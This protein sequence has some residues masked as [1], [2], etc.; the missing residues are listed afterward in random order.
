MKRPVSTHRC[1]RYRPRRCPAE[2]SA[3]DRTDKERKQG[4]GTTVIAAIREYLSDILGAFMPGMYFSLNLLVSTIL[5]V[6]MTKGQSWKNVITFINDLPQSAVLQTVTPFAVFAF[7]L[8]SYIIGSA[9][10]RKDIKEP[11]TASAIQT[12]RKS[13]DKEKEGLAFDFKDAGGKPFKLLSGLYMRMNFRVD[14]PYSHL[15]RYLKTRN[16]THLAE[17]IPWEGDEN[18]EKAKQ[19]SKMFINILKVR[20]H[21]FAPSEMPEIEKNE[22][23]IRLMNSLWYAAKTI[24]NISIPVLISTTAFYILRVLLTGKPFLASL[25]SLFDADFAFCLTAFSAIQ[26]LVAWYIRRSIKQ[27]FHYMRVREIMFLLEIADTITRHGDIDI[28]EGLE[29]DKKEPETSLLPDAKGYTK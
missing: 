10:C 21:Q 1:N 12:Y 13:S 23:H 18:K 8:F 9:F 11:D 26:L 29:P 28:F 25:K 24:R 17:H 19:R 2:D 27:Y 16:Y 20:I 22:A 3:P 15:K 14:F 7:C 5:F 6:L 4:D